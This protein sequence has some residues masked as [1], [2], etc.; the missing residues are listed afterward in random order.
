MTDS[1][2]PESLNAADEMFGVEGLLGAMRSAGPSAQEVLDAVWQALATHQAS[3]TPSDD[4]TVL[5][6]KVKE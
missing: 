3:S 6:L 1:E 2:S 4:Q 5:V